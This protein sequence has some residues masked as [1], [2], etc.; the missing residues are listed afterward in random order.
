M[1]APANSGGT[2]Q[3]AE[4][5]VS[6]GQLTHTANSQTLNQTVPIEHGLKNRPENTPHRWADIVNGSK[7]KLDDKH[8]EGMSGTIAMSTTPSN[9]ITIGQGNT[10]LKPK[11]IKIELSDVEDEIKYWETAVVCFVVGSNPSLHVID[12]FVRRI[13]KDLDI[14]TV[15]TVDSGVFIVRMKTI[16]YR[17]KAYESNGL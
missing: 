15:G 4:E 14:D 12:G 6:D 1:V 2:L 16:E 5:L 7:G 13:W 3:R 10:S 11:S 9:A 17:D 8:P